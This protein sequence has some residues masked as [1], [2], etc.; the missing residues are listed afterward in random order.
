MNITVSLGIQSNTRSI[1]LM[2]S[3]IKA[4]QQRLK[5]EWTQ[6]RGSLKPLEERKPP[7]SRYLVRHGRAIKRNSKGVV[8]FNVE[9]YDTNKI[10]KWPLNYFIIE[11]KFVN[12]TISDIINDWTYTAQEWPNVKRQCLFCKHK[13]M[14]GD[15][16]CKKCNIHFGKVIHP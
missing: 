10:E 1:K 5:K 16:I 7:V 4:A 11:N 2:N 9:M 14:K 12:Q 13:A 3:D 15:I 6:I 8:C